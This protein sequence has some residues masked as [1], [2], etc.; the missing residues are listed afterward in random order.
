MSTKQTA[1]KKPL[2]KQEINSKGQQW[3][4]GQSGNPNGR[5]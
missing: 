2:L 4:R 5:P 3:K 1:T